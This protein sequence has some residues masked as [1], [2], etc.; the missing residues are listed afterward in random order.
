MIW[1]T[2]MTIERYFN[3]ILAHEILVASHLEKYLEEWVPLYDIS[4][5]D[6]FEIDSNNFEKLFKGKDNSA[7]PYD[8]KSLMKHNDKRMRGFCT[9]KQLVGF[10]CQ[11][12]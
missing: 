12:G 8:T 10:Q 11:N 3:L 9:S 2:L 5:Y 4:T 1:D 7:F 6:N